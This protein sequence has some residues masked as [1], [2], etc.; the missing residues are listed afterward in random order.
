MPTLAS[1]KNQL[2][3][4][5]FAMLTISGLINAFGVTVFLAPVSLYDGG[6][7][8]T[9]M[10]LAQITPEFMSLSFFLLVLNIPLFLFGLKKQ[11]IAFTVYSVYAVTI[12]S[13]GAWLITDVLPIDVSIA[14]PFAG[15]DLLLCAVFGGLISGIGSGLTIRNSGA[16]DGVEVMAVIFA[17][18]LNMTVCTFVMAYNVIVYVAAGVLSGS[19][20]LPLYSIV[21]YYVGQ[22]SVDFI[23]EGIDRSKGIMIITDKAE[24]VCTAL[25]DTFQCGTTKIA[26]KGGFSD[27]DKTMIYFVVNLF[28]IARMRNIVQSIDPHSFMTISEVADVF[29][30]NSQSQ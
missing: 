28:Q 17:K 7:S 9:S 19:W 24:E 8:G 21:A 4:R 14:S 30:Y 6:I 1:I 25:M 5:N 11:G 22:N 15:T 20:I 23:V 10:L 2:S 18:K 29:K 16:I 13:L 27:A 26:A 3:L 12:Y